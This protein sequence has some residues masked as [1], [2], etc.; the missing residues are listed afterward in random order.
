MSLSKK[1]GGLGYKDLH[2]FNMAM[3]AKQGWRLLTDPTSLCARVLKAKYFPNS[4]VLHAEPVEGMS[5]TWRSILRGI[6]LLKEGVIKRVGDG[7][8]INIWQDPWVP[9][10]GSPFLITRKGNVVIDCVADLLDPVSG[11]WDVD[12]VDDCLWPADAIHVSKI[13]VCL[14]LEDS[15]AWRLEP[16]GQF[17]VKSAY[18]LH[19]LLLESNGSASGDD[20][21]D[22]ESD[23][24]WKDIW[25]CPCPPNVRQFLWRVA[26]DSLPHR[27]NIA[28]RGIKIDPLCQ[29]CHRLNEDGAHIFLRCKGIRQA[30]AGM[31]MEDVRASLLLCNGPK[32]MLY[33]MLQLELPRKLKGVALLWTWWKHRNKINAGEGKLDVDEVIFNTTRCAAE[34]EQ[35]CVPPP[36][37]KGNIQQSWRPPGDDR[38][39]IN[40]DGSFFQSS[41]SGGWGFVMRNSTGQV[42]A[43]AAGRVDHARNAPQTEAMACIHAIQ[44]ARD[45]GIS[46]VELETDALLLIQAVNSDEFDRAEN[47]VLFKE[48][49]RLLPLSFSFALVKFCPRACNMVANALATHGSKLVHLPQVV[50]PGDAPGFVRSLVA[51][52]SAVLAG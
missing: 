20:S 12:L 34:Y 43:S 5:Y 28:R 31:G 23:F 52:D 6:Q 27:C 10:N 29:V 40:M 1:V 33:K 32:E 22:H 13:L 35:F 11:K 37:Q 36:V 3:L 14:N 17:S 51:S 7:R 9:R 49:K 46:E 48:I 2:S 21:R 41:L 24:A 38:L 45:L 47:G 4:D 18:K 25:A 30:W 15:W 8:S 39:K 50:W 42:V 44:A 16:K 26:H 19:R